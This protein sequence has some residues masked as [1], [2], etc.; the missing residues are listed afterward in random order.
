[1]LYSL[2]THL[3]AGLMAVKTG[4][5]G[6]EAGAHPILE[7]GDILVGEGPPSHSDQLLLPQRSCVLGCLCQQLPEDSYVICRILI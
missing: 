4:E 7:E 6:F 2:D 1:M 3:H 5:A